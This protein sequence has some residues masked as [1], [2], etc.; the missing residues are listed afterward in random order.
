MKNSRIQNPE[1]RSQEAGTEG[2]RRIALGSMSRW[3]KTR[4]SM[5]SASK[6]SSLLQPATGYYSLLKAPG[7]EGVPEKPG[8]LKKFLFSLNL[9]CQPF[10]TLSKAFQPFPRVFPEKKDCL[11][12]GNLA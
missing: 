3:Q 9:P 6:N 12:F 8:Y 11:F 7:G 10:P 1:L 2:V 5:K 4:K